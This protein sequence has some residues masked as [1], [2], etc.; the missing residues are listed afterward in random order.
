MYGSLDID[1][2]ANMVSDYVHNLANGIYKEFE[3]LILHHGE[4]V[5][6]TLMP[7]V[8]S[9]LETMDRVYSEKHNLEVEFELLKEDSSQLMTQY[10]R[11]KSQR[12]IAEEVILFFLIK[13]FIGY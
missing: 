5:V 6:K 4:N 10:E 7:M 2:S 9:C 12:K 1:G 8:V 3:S 11:E 13:I